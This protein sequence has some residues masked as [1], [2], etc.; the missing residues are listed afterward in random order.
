MRHLLSSFSLGMLAC[1]DTAAAWNPWST[2]N[3]VG[4]R[5]GVDNQRIQAYIGNELGF[6]DGILTELPSFDSLDWPKCVGVP[7]PGPQP[8]VWRVIGQGACPE[9]NDLS[10]AWHFYDPRTKKGYYNPPFIQ[11]DNSFVHSLQ[12]DSHSAHLGYPH[13][14]RAFRDTLRNDTPE[15]RLEA[16][17]LMSRSLGHV[18]HLIQDST[19]PQ[20]V[21][22][23][24]HM[25]AFG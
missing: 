10:G 16:L 2:H 6:E 7:D 23:D 12:V 20:H 21:R 4:E 3:A 25:P 14:R 19:Q 17:A 22:D 1:A 8:P 9:D 11:F 5:V 24:A 18:L 15:E 13:A